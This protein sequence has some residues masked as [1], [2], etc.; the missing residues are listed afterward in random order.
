MLNIALTG[1]IAAGKSTVV[2]R[3]A[4]KGASV[5]DAD[6]L[7]REAVAPGTPGLEKIVQRFGKPMLCADGTLDRAALRK[8]VFTDR[9]ELEALNAIVHPD[10]ARRREALVQAARLRGERILISDIPL[11]FETN[12]ERGFDRVILID[13]PVDMRL[14]RLMLERGLPEQEARDM[15]AAQM[16]ATLKRR[17]ADIVI[18]ND[19]SKE[20][21]LARVDSVWKDLAPLATAA[22]R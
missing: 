10:V 9:R 6:L 5:I 7:A 19:G 15:I 20:N 2:R 12:G 11:L 22:A 14:A 18:D 16:P 8:R 3:M 13:A 1:N 21:L 4:E 17:R